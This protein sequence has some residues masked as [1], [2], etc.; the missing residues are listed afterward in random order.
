[1]D[2]RHP[3]SVQ[4]IVIIGA[5][6]VGAALAYRLSQAG[7]SVTVIEAAHPASA[8]SG[9]SFGW[10]NA[11]FFH[12]DAHF[13][14]RAEGIA[15]HHRLDRDLGD[16]GT[17]WP[18]TLWWEEEGPALDTQ[19]ET[20]RNL[21]Y[22]VETLS[23]NQITAREPLLSAPDRCLFL[24][25]EGAVD[26]AHLTH[27][28]LSAANAPVWRGTPVRGIETVQ[29]RVTGVRL[30]QG[31][32]IADQVILA[33]GTA[34]AGLLAPL[35][36]TLPMLHRPG[37]ILRTKPVAARITHIL[38]SPVQEVRQDPQGR[39]IAPLAASH[40][41]DTTE[42][43]PSLPGD[44]AIAA[45]M[46]LGALLPGI[47]LTLG[48]VTLAHRPVPGDNL[49]AI[50]P[51]GIPGL[52]LAVMHSGVTLTAI[53]AELVTAEVLTGANSPLL[54]SFRPTRFF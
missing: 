54:A 22:R 39:L 20:L 29:G 13:N 33:A 52:S 40:Q 23:H 10:I 42:V 44:L 24:P 30:D 6:L 49:P 41:S 8:A 32:V 4:R 28:L 51:T 25:D 19:A 18:G 15:A 16:T 50:G 17:Q 1:S 53:V 5:G 11:S 48:D 43:I 46:R 27:R 26:A 3:S 36:L 37:L 9:A 38:A 12:S 7:A 45:M 47:A 31:S 35:G 34:C 21:G 2:I 14:L